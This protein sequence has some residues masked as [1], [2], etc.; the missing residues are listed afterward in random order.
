MEFKDI[1]EFIETNKESN[2]EVKAYLQ[3]FKQF[4]VDEVQKFIGENEEGKKWFDSER[5]RFFNKSLD[6]W[7]TNNLEK[8]IT[9][10]IK[11]RNPDK[12]PE[13]IELEKL[14]ADFEE[15]QRQLQLKGVKE[16][17]TS[18]ASEKKI[19]LELLDFFIN[20]DEEKTTENLSTFERVMEKYVKAQVDE[21]LQSSYQPPGNNNNVGGKNPFKKETFNLTEQAR[22]YKENPELAKQLAAQAKQ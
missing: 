16:K 7:K 21:R 11:K 12:T 3:G 17:A 13:Q 5:D 9:E 2:E 10:E 20:Q 4:G 18:I 1:K 8:L 15:S 22:L 14:R 6:T 19:P